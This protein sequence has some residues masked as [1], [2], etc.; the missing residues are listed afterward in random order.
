M[1]RGRI[2]HIEP[3]GK[4][5]AATG[6]QVRRRALRAGEIDIGRHDVGAVRCKPKCDSAAVALPRT[7]DERTFTGKKIL[8]AGAH[9]AFSARCRPA[10]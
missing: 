8:E 9:A 5:F 4:S 6:A 10:I 1:A 3:E 2:R 7:S